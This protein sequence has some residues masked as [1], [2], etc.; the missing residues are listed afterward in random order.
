M[1]STSRTIHIFRWDI[2]IDTACVRIN[3]HNNKKIMYIE[4]YTIVIGHYNP[5]LYVSMYYRERQ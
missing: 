1:Q 3:D 5:Y 2:Q 4:D